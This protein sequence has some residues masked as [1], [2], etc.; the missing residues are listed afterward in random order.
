MIALR[1]FGGEA[2]TLPAHL[3]P[4]TAAQQADFCDF[5]HGHLQPM[6]QG[7]LLKTM[8]AT[9]KTIYTDDG[10]LFYTWP[11]ETYALQGPVSKDPYER[12]YFL[13]A[14]VLRVTTRAGLTVNGGPPALSYKVGVPRPTSAPGLARVDLT[15]YPDYPGAAI[16]VTAWW[17]DLSIRY[18]EAAVVLTQVSRL[19]EYTFSMPARS[20]G[21]P[22]SAVA[23]I[24][25]K[26]LDAAG[27]AFVTATIDPGDA[28]ARSTALPGNVTF[29]LSQAAGLSFRLVLDYGIAETRAYVYTTKNSWLEESP[30]SPAQTIATTYLQSVVV[31]LGAVDFTDYRPLSGY[32]TYRT[33]GAAASYLLVKESLLLSFTD[34]SSKF[35]DTLGALETLDYENPPPLLSAMIAMAGGTFVGF[36]GNTLYESE[37][38][39]PHSWQHQNT[40]KK[41]IRSVCEAPQAIVVT[42]AEGCY[43]VVGS[44]PAARQPIRLPTPQA[45]IAQRSVANLDGVTA[46]ASNDGIVSVSG[47]QASLLGSQKLFARDD[48]QARY[49]AILADASMRFAWHDGLLIATSATQALGFALA[50]DGEATGQYTQFNVRMD[51]MFQL[52]VADTL[53]YRVGADVFQ[54]RGSSAPYAYTWWSKDFIFPRDRNLGAGYIRCSGPVTLTL[55]MDG[56]LELDALV[57]G[58]RPLSEAADALDELERGDVLR[59]LLQ[60]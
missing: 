31:T 21:T 45:G 4:E 25:F 35:S 59:Q 2:P 44:K 60:P 49:G 50:L 27:K 41:S 36:S 11:T 42:T 30:P 24:T 19:R 17:E 52:P 12:I 43:T 38:Y 6:K 47:S 56:A 16:V 15:E 53:Y 33:I 46:F 29:T 14:G 48:W 57:S 26:A 1:T 32:R 5:T 7:F 55:Y 10:V 40:F 54:F 13:G 39:R 9:V 18:Q 3:L 22:A 58:R 20:G 8:A 51:S 37:P 23:R 28:G 34:T